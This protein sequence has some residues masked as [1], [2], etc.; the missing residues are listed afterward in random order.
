MKKSIHSGHRKRVKER[1]L[2]SE[3]EQ[4]NE[5]EILEMLLFYAIPLKDTNPL[6]HELINKF[7]SISSVLDASPEELRKCGL[8]E[9]AA[10]YLNS[11]PKICHSYLHDKNYSVKKKYSETELQDKIISYCLESPKTKFIM[12]LFDAVS[13]ELFFGAVP[14]NNASELVKNANKLAVKYYASSVTLCTVMENGIDYPSSED[15]AVVSVIAKNMSSVSIKLREW[16][17]ISDSQLARMSEEDEFISLFIGD[18]EDGKKQ[19]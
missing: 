12:I 5:H 8:S 13:S 16:Y 10:G 17:V 19:H 2:N 14:Y 4:F 15:I 18:F 9:R 3:F 1:F 6:A 11:L 7:G